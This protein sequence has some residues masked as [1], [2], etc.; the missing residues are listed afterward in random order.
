MR[1]VSEIQRDRVVFE[2]E[3]FEYWHPVP[4]CIPI[5]QL[6]LFFNSGKNGD[7]IEGY[8]K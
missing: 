6:S 1:D 8:L 3:I 4:L 5:L 2:S 7:E